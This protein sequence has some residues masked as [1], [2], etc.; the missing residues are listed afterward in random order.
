[1]RDDPDPFAEVGGANIGRSQHAPL[2]IIPEGGKISQ[3]DFKP[4]LLETRRVFSEDKSRS[5]L[6]HDSGHF[7]PESRPGSRD[8]CSGA[9]AG[10]I[11]T[12]EASRYDVNTAS[13]C[14]SV[15]GAHVIPD[16]IR[17]KRAVILPCEK[18]G[19]GEPVVLDGADGLPSEKVTGE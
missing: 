5:Y 1:M 16:R 2:H 11:L 6:S 15:K 4:E 19:G 18:N 9:C 12:W 10:Y 17:G 14:S 7:F 8:S 13:P 3:D